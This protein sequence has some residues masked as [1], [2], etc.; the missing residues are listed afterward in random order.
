MIK[1]LF[2]VVLIISTIVCFSQKTKLKSNLSNKEI[3]I[4]NWFVPH[5]ANINIKFY[6]SG[7][8]EFIDINSD[9]FEELL[10]G[11]YRLQNGILTLLYYDRPKQ[12]FKFYKGV[13][14]DSNYYIR[15]GEYYFV[16]GENGN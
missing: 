2:L 3:L 13:N 8:F 10:T 15:K 6:R 5:Y 4:G 14:G 11:T 9:G 1:K 12:N 16:K 7:R